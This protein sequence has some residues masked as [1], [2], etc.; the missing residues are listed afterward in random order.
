[1]RKMWQRGTQRQKR[2]L[3]QECIKP[4]GNT[5]VCMKCSPVI[6]LLT[7]RT[8][9]KLT[10][11]L[12]SVHTLGQYLQTFKAHHQLRTFAHIWDSLSA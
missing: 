2:K 11:G 4:D 1:M 7:K 12:L 5:L 6:F 9:F 3:T 10:P 8:C